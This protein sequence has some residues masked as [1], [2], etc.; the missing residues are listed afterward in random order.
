MCDQA[1]KFSTASP[2]RC[3]T[4]T[5]RPFSRGRLATALNSDPTPNAWL[6]LRQPPQGSKDFDFLRATSCPWWFNISLA[7]SLLSNILPVTPF[8]ARICRLSAGSI[9]GKYNR[10]NC[11]QESIPKKNAMNPRSFLNGVSQVRQ[12]SLFIIPL[13]SLPFVLG[14]HEVLEGK[15]T[16]AFPWCDFVSFVVICSGV[17]REFPR[18]K[19]PSPKG[20]KNTRGPHWHS[21]TKSTNSGR[22][23]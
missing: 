14:R 9:C 8:D 13:P 10:I 20:P 4:P 21:T 1:A 23:S 18:Q 22:R 2:L 11:M 17:S 19:M 3:V 16:D 6:R 7:K 5:P 15:H 12:N